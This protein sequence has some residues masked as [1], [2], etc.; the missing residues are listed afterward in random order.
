LDTEQQ[1]KNAAFS[2]LVGE[3]KLY[4]QA[5]LFNSTQGLM[6]SVSAVKGTLVGRKA[7]QGGVIPAVDFT[8]QFWCWHAPDE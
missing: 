3:D 2:Y 4:F 8:P 5:T 6:D 1:V 7:S